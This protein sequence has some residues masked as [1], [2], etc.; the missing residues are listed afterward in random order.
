MEVNNLNLK[1]MISLIMVFTLMATFTMPALSLSELQPDNTYFDYKYNAKEQAVAGSPGYLP[2]ER[3]NSIEGAGPLNKPTDIYV[4]T[5][6]VVYIL[7][8]GN[9]R[10]VVLDKELKFLKTV[11]FTDQNQ[12]PL[13]FM[14]ATGLFVDNNCRILIADGKAKKV[15]IFSEK[16]EYL[17]V[18][19]EPVSDVLP[20]GFN[21][22]PQKVL[23]DDYGV[24]YVLS[25]G[26]YSGILQYKS[27]KTFIGFYGAEKV[28]V[29]MSLLMDQFW[30]KILSTA[31]AQGMRKYVP[32]EYTSI[33]IDQQGF[34]YGVKND[35]DGTFLGQLKRLNPLGEN[36]LWYNGRGS[37][38]R[39]GE[40][41][42]YYS[43]QS[44]YIDSQFADLVYDN[45]GFINLLDKRKGRIFQY[46]LNANLLFSFGGLGSEMGTFSSPV[47]IETVGSRIL[48]IDVNDSALTVFEE[49]AF[50]QLYH[51][52]A[53]LNRK[54]EN[55]EAFEIWETVLETDRYDELAN[56]GMGK[57]LMAKGEY[58]DS[59][60]YFRNA[61]SRENYS[62]A[63]K[64]YRNMLLVDN[65]VWIM[66]ALLV[67]VAAWI[68]FCKFKKKRVVTEYDLKVSKQRMPFYAMW[69]P[70]K[71]YTMLKE[72][73]QGSA[74][75]TMLIVAAFL[76]MSIIQRQATGFLFNYQDPDSFNIIYML[77][78]TVGL[79]LFFTISNWAV[80]TL[81]DGEGKFKEIWTFTGYAILPYVMMM[82]PLV[83]ASHFLTLDESAFYQVALTASYIWA[84]VGV[85]MAV[86]EAH[87]YTMKKTVFNLLLTLVGMVLVI[88]M[89][90]IIYSVVTQLVTFIGSIASEIALR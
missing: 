7:D 51:Q 79:F 87:Q 32:V 16:G 44:G 88:V 72:E 18:L 43:A 81:M 17:D 29:T 20:Q 69:H 34:I 3:Y 30:K 80:S 12:E 84:G 52:G 86:K 47:A 42:V 53:L 62:E 21:Y 50:G 35:S 85:V 6:N 33:D 31:Q 41:E 65:F 57:A 39:Y 64:D 78:S 70:F 1:K 9:N 54:G 8:A 10:V 74:F 48:V 19:G 14:D 46:D 5:D 75:Y 24:Y 15:Y 38:R 73:K 82:I 49:T 56:L 36:V 13:A 55:E 66:L 77:F 11:T 45:N 89:M 71:A 67:I 28:T 2:K 63:Y 90:A 27:D 4:S 58:K 40:M 61:D 26:S 59:L 23:C 22:V 76:V 68:V 60:Q 25:K 83:L 37:V